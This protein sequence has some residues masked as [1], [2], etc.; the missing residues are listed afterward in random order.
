M[1]GNSINPGLVRFTFIKHILHM[2]MDLD[3]SFPGTSGNNDLFTGPFV[4]FFY[5]LVLVGA[6]V[7]TGG[8]ERGPIQLGFAS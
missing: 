2:D 8:F 1:G 3:T 6:V 7:F 5:C 4:E